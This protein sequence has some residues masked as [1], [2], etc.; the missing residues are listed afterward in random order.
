M[1]CPLS[2]LLF[3]R[4]TEPLG[5]GMGAVAGRRERCSFDGNLAL[6]GGDGPRASPRLPASLSSSLRLLACAETPRSCASAL[7]DLAARGRGGRLV[8]GGAGPGRSR[9]AYWGA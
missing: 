1:G 3:V 9:V 2:P 6:V 4:V 8:A 7:V 5:R